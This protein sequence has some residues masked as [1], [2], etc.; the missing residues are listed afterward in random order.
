MIKKDKNMK[1]KNKLIV[2]KRINNAIKFKQES[3]I[4]YYILIYYII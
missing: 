1:I 4:I 2:F 3:K